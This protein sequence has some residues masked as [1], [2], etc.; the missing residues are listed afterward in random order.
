MVMML[1]VDRDKRRYSRCTLQQLLRCS[2]HPLF[3][4]KEPDG[5]IP[6]SSR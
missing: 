4:L 3:V 6:R 2:G 1:M 5:I